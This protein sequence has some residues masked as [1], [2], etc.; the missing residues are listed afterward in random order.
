MDRD[1]RDLAFTMTLLSGVLVVAAAMLPKQRAALGSL[2]G[3]G[4]ATAGMFLRIG[5]KKGLPV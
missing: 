5:Q 1:A 4:L 2:A 3:V